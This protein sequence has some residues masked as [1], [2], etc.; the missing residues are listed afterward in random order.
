[1]LYGKKGNYATQVRVQVEWGVWA[2]VVSVRN[3]NTRI[4]HGS[5]PLLR[6]AGFCLPPTSV[7]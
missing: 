4:I 3:G 6:I 2:Q 7:Q 5:N 1:M